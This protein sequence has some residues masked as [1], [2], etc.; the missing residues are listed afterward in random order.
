MKNVLDSHTFA[1]YVDSL[2]IFSDTCIVADGALVQRMHTVL[3]LNVGQRCVFFNKIEH[4]QVKIIKIDKKKV[5]AKI[6]KAQKNNIFQPYI[7]VGL[8]L[9]KKAALEDAVYSA[10]EMGVSEIRLIT[11][12]KSRKKLV[13]NEW[14]RLNRIVIAAAEQSKNYAIPVLQ[15]SLEPLELFVEKC[16]KDEHVKLFFDSKGCFVQTI[17]KSALQSPKMVLLIGP[18]GDFLHKE[19]SCLRKENWLFVSLTATI[20]RSFQAVGLAIGIVRSLLR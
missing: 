11:S 10:V 7:V 5:E 19:K 14:Q 6:I 17:K 20:L 3:R 15:E 9:L 4:A 18:E 12:E 16:R 13:I 1:F 2:N 8:P